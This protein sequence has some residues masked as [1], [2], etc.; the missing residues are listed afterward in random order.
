MEEKEKA[1][2]KEKEK[3]KNRVSFRT[4]LKDI[5]WIFHVVAYDVSS[6][7][8]PLYVHFYMTN[9]SRCAVDRCVRHWHW[10]WF[11]SYNHCFTGLWIGATLKSIDSTVGRRIITTLPNSGGG[12]DLCASFFILV[13]P[14]VTLVRHLQLQL[15]RTPTHRRLLFTLTLRCWYRVTPSWG[16]AHSQ[17]VRL[18]SL[19]PWFYYAT[20]LSAFPLSNASRYILAPVSGSVSVL[21]KHTQEEDKRRIRR[22]RCCKGCLIVPAK[23]L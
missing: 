2:E 22:G 20:L 3:K 21:N 10:C 23:M 17:G 16:C 12:A 7:W 13:Y 6:T 19:C 14:Y 18:R 1:K 4:S 8:I 11:C 9:V 15:Y 5:N